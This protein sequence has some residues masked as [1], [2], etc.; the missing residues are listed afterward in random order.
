M[1]EFVIIKTLSTMITQI[2]SSAQISSGDAWK[3]LLR[4]SK[5]QR[6]NSTT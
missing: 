1:K 2:T 6:S 5:F 3:R 4:N